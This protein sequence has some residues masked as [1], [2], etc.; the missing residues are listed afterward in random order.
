MKHIHGGVMEDEPPV[1]DE[2]EILRESSPNEGYRGP[3]V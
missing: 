2:S 1:P 3:S